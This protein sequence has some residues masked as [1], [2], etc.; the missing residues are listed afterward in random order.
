MHQEVEPTLDCAPPTDFR[1]KIFDLSF[2]D[3]RCW[4]EQKKKEGQ[5]KEII[6]LDNTYRKQ[7]RFDRPVEWLKFIGSCSLKDLDRCVALPTI[8]ERKEIEPRGRFVF[9]VYDQEDDFWPTFS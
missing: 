8:W 9:A 6:E 3:L 5:S 7:H 4:R 1:K 2:S